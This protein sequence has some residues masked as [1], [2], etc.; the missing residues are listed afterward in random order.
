[1]VRGG[2]WFDFARLVRSAY[3]GAYEPVNRNGYLGF[4]CLRVQQEKE[5]K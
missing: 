3:R 2:S 5:S 4:R 1:V